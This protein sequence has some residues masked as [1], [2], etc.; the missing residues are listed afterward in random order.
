MR[1]VSFGEINIFQQKTSISLLMIM[2]AVL[3]F[4]AGLGLKITHLKN[5]LRIKH[6]LIAGL[7][8]NLAIPVVYVFGMTIAMRLWY[9]SVGV[10]CP[11]VP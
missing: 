4:N 9:E 5:I 11:C 8:T 2:L 6:V 3:M 10:L 7:G 1:D